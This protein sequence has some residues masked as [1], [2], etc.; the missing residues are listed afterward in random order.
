[1][2]YIDRVKNKDKG[3]R[4]S[5]EVN[6]TET[7]DNGGESAVLDGVSQARER[8]TKLAHESDGETS[9]PEDDIAASEKEEKI[10]KRKMKRARTTDDAE[11]SDSAND[12]PPCPYGTSCYRSVWNLESF[13]CADPSDLIKATHAQNRDPFL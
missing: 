5:S 10:T 1:M 2:S 3:A 12:L 9:E 6:S 7:G 4:Q 8:K 13:I 11:A